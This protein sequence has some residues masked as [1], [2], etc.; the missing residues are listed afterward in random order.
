MPRRKGTPQKLTAAV[1]K[2]ICDALELSLTE[3]LAAE[4]AGI[5]ETTFY[6]WMRK[7]DDGIEPYQSFRDAVIRARARGAKNLIMRGLKG[8]KGSQQAL[9]LLER[10]YRKEYGPQLLVRGAPEAAPINID[11]EKEAAAAIR[12]CPEASR[13][14]HESLAAAVAHADEQRAKSQES[15]GTVRQE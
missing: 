12:S 2:E 1:Q 5:H 14:M 3:N 11:R 6:D 9:W 4:A 8:E 7:G 10:R 13:L 15:H